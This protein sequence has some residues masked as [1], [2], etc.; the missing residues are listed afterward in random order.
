MSKFN[1][2]DKVK[3]SLIAD[4]PS[5]NLDGLHSNFSGI[6]GVIDDVFEE[7]Y[8]G[9]NALY[10]GK[11]VIVYSF[12]DDDTLFAE[13]ELE[14]EMKQRNG[15][16]S[17]SSSS[18]YTI[19]KEQELFDKVAGKKTL[20]KANSNEPKNNDGRITCYWCDEPTKQIQG[21]MNSYDVCE[22]CGK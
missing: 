15:F 11:D 16:V 14:L 18:S 3:V 22:G 5:L 4:D 9:N 6:I 17:N 20:T 2:G 21:F 10:V 7:P 12:I 13:Y 19:T 8:I 1:I